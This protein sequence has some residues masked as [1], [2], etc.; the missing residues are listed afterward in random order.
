M[1]FHNYVLLYSNRVN[2]AILTGYRYLCA[3]Y[4]IRDNLQVSQELNKKLCRVK[5]TNAYISNIWGIV[6]GDTISST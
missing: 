3:G 6:Y 1:H 4:K 2:L 5:K